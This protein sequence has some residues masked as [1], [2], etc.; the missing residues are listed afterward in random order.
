MSCARTE[1]IGPSHMFRQCGERDSESAHHGNTNLV[2][3]L[4]ATGWSESIAECKDLLKRAAT[5]W[6]ENLG[7]RWAPDMFEKG[8]SSSFL[9]AAHLFKSTCINNILFIQFI[10]ILGLMELSKNSLLDPRDSYHFALLAPYLD[11]STFPDLT[12]VHQYFVSVATTSFHQPYT[13]Q[14]LQQLGAMHARGILECIQNFRMESE[15]MFPVILPFLTHAIDFSTYIGHSINSLFYSENPSGMSSADIRCESNIHIESVAQLEAVCSLTALPVAVMTC[16]AVARDDD[17]WSPQ[18]CETAG[19]VI[20]ISM[21]ATISLVLSYIRSNNGATLIPSLRVISK[22]LSSFIEN[23]VN[24]ISASVLQRIITNAVARN[25][26]IVSNAMCDLSLCTYE[27]LR[28]LVDRSNFETLSTVQRISIDECSHFGKYASTCNELRWNCLKH[29]LLIY[30]SIAIDS[31]SMNPAKVLSTL[32]DMMELSP[33]Q[34]LPDISIC[35]SVAANSLIR[36]EMSRYQSLSEEAVAIIRACIDTYWRTCMSEEILE[37]THVFAFVQFTFSKAIIEHSN[38]FGI[39]VSL[40]FY[41]FS[42]HLYLMIFRF[43]RNTSTW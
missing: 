16:V 6:A 41:L 9:F 5:L 8:T 39:R 19:K 20:D 38:L 26:D 42:R 34:S 3:V 25:I 33:S 14:S 22:I 15:R 4:I 18:I 12:A 27:E 13:A 32:L 17:W 35:L 11:A 29:A 30:S 43:P 24:V 21:G 37:C 31:Y 1:S 36:S 40:L 2:D 28:V 10:I 7:F 23:I